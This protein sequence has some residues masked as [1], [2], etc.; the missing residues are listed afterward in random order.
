MDSQY[1]VKMA[2]QIAGFFSAYP[3]EEQAISEV[4]NH[5]CRFWDPR[6]RTALMDHVDAGTASGLSA[7]AKSGIRRA[8]KDT[9]NTA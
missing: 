2:N 8:M 4:A 1:L 5:M 6:M 7:L 3:D 9:A